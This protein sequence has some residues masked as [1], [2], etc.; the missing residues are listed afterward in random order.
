MKNIFF[1]NKN[2]HFRQCLSKDPE[3]DVLH[4]PTH[5]FAT[6]LSRGVSRVP[7]RNITSSFVQQRTF[8]F[9]PLV[10]FL[11]ETKT[12]QT[13]GDCFYNTTRLYFILVSTHLVHISK[14][15]YIFKK[16][17]STQIERTR[18]YTRDT[19]FLHR[20]RKTFF[21]YHSA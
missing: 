12:W 15:Q 10:S 4:Q 8:I 19:S 2:V 13:V 17:N 6:Q 21:S 5:P 14:G 16:I 1:Q 9:Q 11:Q 3:P 7:S 20:N 18:C